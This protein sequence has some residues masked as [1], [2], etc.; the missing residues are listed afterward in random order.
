MCGQKAFPLHG[1]VALED[2]V[3]LIPGGYDVVRQLRSAEPS[4]G[5]RFGGVSVI[6]DYMVVSTFLMGLQLEFVENLKKEK[7]TTV[8]KNPSEIRQ[9]CLPV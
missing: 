2:H 9:R 3:H 4:E 8:R 6:N 7:K 5:V 1:L